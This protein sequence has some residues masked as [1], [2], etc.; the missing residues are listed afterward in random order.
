MASATSCNLL[1]QRLPADALEEVME[2]SELVQYEL[3]QVLIEPGEPIKY[4]VFPESGVLS[5]LSRVDDDTL[6]ELATIGKEGMLGVSAAFGIC[7]VPEI[8]VCQ[9]YSSAR[10]LEV[11]TFQALIAKYPEFLAVCHRY[12]VGLFSQ[13]AYTTGCNRSHSIQQRCA[14]WMLHTLDRCEGTKFPMTQEALAAMLGVSRTGVNLAAGLL[15]KAKVINYVRGRVTVLNRKGL[16]EASCD[17]Y[18]R[19][20]KNF[21]D[22]MA[23]KNS[24]MCS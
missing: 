7:T 21:E 10:R 19:M 1:L 8:V 2:K 18:F 4:V 11:K 6:I 13:V 3:R 20:D 16:E 12:T 22:V 9:V 17:C 15:A 5:L 24:L 14:R 23:T